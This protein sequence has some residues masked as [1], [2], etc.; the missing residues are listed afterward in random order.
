MSKR[1]K[2]GI[3]ILLNFPLLFLFARTVLGVTASDL[4]AEID[5]LL[6]QISLLQQ[7]LSQASS[8]SPVPQKLLNAFTRNLSLGSQ[9]EDVR[10]LQIVLNKDSRTH[11]KEIGP[12][13]S[14]NETT[15][16]GPATKAAVIKFQELYMAEILTPAGLTSGSGFVGEKTRAKLTNMTGAMANQTQSVSKYIPPEADISKQQSDL[17]TQDSDAVY[18]SG[19]SDVEVK[20]GGSLTL[21]GSGYDAVKNTVRIGERSI[22]NIPSL[23]GATLTFTVPVDLPIDKHYVTVQN[24][25]GKESDPMLFVVIKDNPTRPLIQALSPSEGPYGQK[26]IITGQN[27]SATKND[28]LSSYAIIEDIPSPDGKTLTFEVLPFPEIPELQV[29]VDL[30]KGFELPLYFYVVN[31]N[32]ISEKYSPGKYLLKI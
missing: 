16:F 23:D 20:R 3:A 29:G 6:K 4:Q 31:E 18:I 22:P 11:V 25:K 12:G 14:G 32:G 26:I 2:Y 24:A 28:I 19:L 30:K 13:S 21:M 9:G 17:F 7:E 10:Q 27:F 5:R 8:A 1:M 15:Y